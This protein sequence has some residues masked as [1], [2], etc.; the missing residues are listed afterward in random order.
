[1]KCH[2]LTQRLFAVLA[3]LVCTFFNQAVRAQD[4]LVEIDGGADQSRQSY[5]WLVTNHHS[6][7]I[8]YIEFPHYHA[9]TFTVPHRWKQEST[10][11]VGV[12]VPD[13][14][15]VC[16]AH[17]EPPNTGIAAGGAQRFGMRIAAAGAPVGQGT[18]KVRF[19]DGK[20]ISV[21]GVS[22]PESP[23]TDFKHLPLLG[24]ALLFGGWVVVRT[25]RER[26]REAQQQSMASEK[27]SNPP[28]NGK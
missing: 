1:M 6:S 3:P 23:A 24:A 9:D 5:E 28:G 12:G 26:R 15:G 2:P 21:P 18:V 8:V 7:P 27:A 19:A 4:Q 17:P 13:R 14:P 11:L 10:F 20:E 25:L 16:I 22:L